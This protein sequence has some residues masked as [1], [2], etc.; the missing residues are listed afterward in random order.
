[1]K[2]IIFLLAVHL[3]CLQSFS[4]KKGQELLDSMIQELPRTKED[5]NKVNLLV[6]ISRLYTTIHPKEGFQYAEH[7]MKLASKLDWK[8]GIA[9]LD[10]NLGLLTGDTG[11]NTLAREYFEKSFD[12]NKEL[13]AKAAM[14]ANLNNIGRSYQRETNFPKASEYYFKAMAIAEESGNDE[15][16]ALVGTNLTALYMNQ[17]DYAKAESYAL[18]TI[19]KGEAG[20]ALIH[21][22][23]GYELLGVIKLEKKDTAAARENFEKAL[24][25]N[26]QLGNQ[27]AVVSVL[28]NLGTMEADPEKQ[29]AV[30]I[31]VQ[32]ILDSIAP[33]SQ[34][35]ILNLANLGLTYYNLGMLKQGN[36]RLKD[37]D[38]ADQYLQRGKA[39]CKSTHNPEY[40]ADISQV[41]S[42]LEETR[43][44]YKDA[45]ESFKH[46]SG[47]NDSIYSQDTK[48]KM[49]AIESQRAIDLKN[50]EIEN[51][52]LQISNQHK[53]MWL[54]ASVIAFLAIIAGL[55][56]Y[57][58]NLRKKTNTQLLTLNNELDE[59]NKVKA[60]FFGILGHDL[61]SPVANLIN[62]MQLQKRKPG[63]MSEVQMADRENRITDSARSLLETMEAMLLWS[64]GQ[65]EHFKPDM[66]DVPVSRLFEYLQNFF[67]ETSQV[68]FSYINDRNVMVHT[69]ENYLKCIMLNL[70][71][72][73]V[74]A[75]SQ[76]PDA[77]VDWKAY[78]DQQHVLLS[79]T[80]NG[81]GAD[82]SKLQALYDETTSSGGKNGLGLHI[83]RDLAKSIGCKITLQKDLGKGT[84]FVLS[85]PVV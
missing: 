75:L 37:F 18:L 80:D 22:S 47:I 20:H 81:S 50:K 13:D 69:D 58:S 41:I 9:N 3:L 32:K 71:A 21:V 11:N 2:R 17:A 79:I 74:K 19:K 56:F 35:A 53:R 39:L 6:Q 1:V 46:Y 29:I 33:A 43:G 38:Q 16:A 30:Y 5:T 54:L 28:T 68:A 31:Q 49:A 61:R 4:Q 26:E 57:Q 40:D 14:I 82:E 78:T 51:E 34:N 65:M 73:A 45:L 7:G 85:F 48:N 23:K 10:N 84:T 62:Y 52:K 42:Q 44:N 77:S 66:A 63:L 76:I 12:I 60:K 70:T 83:I 55:I 15:Q 36:E 67:T 24:S 64:K 72:N 25:I 27:L 59:A 8:K